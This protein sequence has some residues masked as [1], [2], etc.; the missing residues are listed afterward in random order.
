MRLPV[1]STRFVVEVVYGLE[2]LCRFNKTQSQSF[3]TTL[4]TPLSPEATI[5]GPGL[6]LYEPPSSLVVLPFDL[7]KATIAIYL[8]AA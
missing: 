1:R 6:A 5:I 2:D 7:A 4:R 3:S 8:E